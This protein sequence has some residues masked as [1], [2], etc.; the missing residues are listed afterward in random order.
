MRDPQDE[1]D[2]PQ[3]FL[4][5]ADQRLQE[6]IETS[7]DEEAY[8]N[9]DWTERMYE[10]AAE[11]WAEAEQEKLEADANHALDQLKEPRL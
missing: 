6:Q 8:T 4:D 3:K 11:L 7:V 2:I 9:G 1:Q 10:L 5:L